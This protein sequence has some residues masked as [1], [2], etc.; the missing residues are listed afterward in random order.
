[1]GL[2]LSTA[3]SE[4]AQ[5]NLRQSNIELQRKVTRLEKEIKA[6]INQ[7]MESLD[8]LKAELTDSKKILAEQKKYYENEIKHI[9]DKVSFFRDKSS[10]SEKKYKLLES[11]CSELQN[12]NQK[13]LSAIKTID[14][15]SD[16]FD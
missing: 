15:I 2:S 8:R 16:K 13:L 12:D 5:H 6:T 9:D 14:D 4:H 1:M 10:E 7:N 3:V 11:K